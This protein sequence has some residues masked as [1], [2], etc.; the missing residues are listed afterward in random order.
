M[1]YSNMR[2]EEIMNSFKKLILMDFWRDVLVIS[3]FRSL[4]L[5]SNDSSRMLSL[6]SLF[7]RFLF[8]RCILRNFDKVRYFDHNVLS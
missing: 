3:S 5:W 6:G 8:S 7:Y 4:K 2:G 1:L